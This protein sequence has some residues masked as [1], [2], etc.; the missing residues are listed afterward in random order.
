MATRFTGFPT[1]TFTF[2]RALARHNDRE[3]FTAHRDAYD[4]ACVEP[5]LAFIEAV[6]PRVKA[7]SPG[8]EFDA[9]L[10]GSLLRIHRDVRFSRDAKPFKDYLDVWFW[11][12]EDK[13]RD[14]PSF[15][16]RL[17][18]DR[19]VVGAGMRVL[20]GEQLAAYREAVD[21]NKTGRKLAA[22]VE[23]LCASGRYALTGKQLA[24]VPS[25]YAADHPRAD[26]LRRTGL[27]VCR[28]GPVGKTAGTARF[29][30]ECV[31]HFAAMAPVCRWLTAVA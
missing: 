27:F 6:G 5:T 23:D 10:G 8:I 19:I 12:G 14:A 15:C 2:L 25:G 20:A 18:A 4:D 31:E 9:K 26:L 11:R 21:A 17:F 7:L 13:G 24:R 30:S 28:E 1:E 3:W 16:V 22:V 29:A